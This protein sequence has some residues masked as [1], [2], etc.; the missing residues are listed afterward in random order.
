MGRMQAEL[1]YM[2]YE[3]IVTVYCMGYETFLLLL[4]L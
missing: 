2:L 1:F 3:G 4:S